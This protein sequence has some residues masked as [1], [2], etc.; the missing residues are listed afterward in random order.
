MH[1]LTDGRTNVHYDL[2]GCFR[3]QKYHTMHSLSRYKE[4]QRFSR[5][6][7]NC[8]CS[9]TPLANYCYWHLM[10][11]VLWAVCWSS[12]SAL[13][14]S[15]VS[16]DPRMPDI[17]LMDTFWSFLGLF[18]IKINK[19]SLFTPTTDL[20]QLNWEIFARLR[21]STQICNKCPTVLCDFN[22]M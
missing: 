22:K 4:K 3:S 17:Y 20:L 12:V 18:I 13:D 14:I 1:W 7:I 11:I 10:Q 8:V 5:K 19:D 2:L 6:K 21:C 15:D 9:F 16:T